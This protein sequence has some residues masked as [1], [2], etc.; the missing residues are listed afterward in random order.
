MGVVRGRGRRS[1]E[2][3]VT[4]TGQGPEV[5]LDRCKAELETFCSRKNKFR[6]STR[7]ILPWL[8]LVNWIC[9]YA[10]LFFSHRAYIRMAP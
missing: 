7:G 1:L 10:L 4:Y 3:R 9:C 6:H 8:V 2:S 5:F